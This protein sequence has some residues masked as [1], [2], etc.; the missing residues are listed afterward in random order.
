MTLTLQ[1]AIAALG[2]DADDIR[3]NLAN[4]K[5]K[6]KKQNIGICPVAI[7][8]KREG[9]PCAYVSQLGIYGSSITRMNTPTHVAAFINR[10]DDGEFPELE[11]NTP[12][13]LMKEED[14]RR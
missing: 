10:F 2:S 6:G 4:W 9:F 12:S 8:L 5:I 7:Y 1:E 3:S 14:I 11:D 13:K